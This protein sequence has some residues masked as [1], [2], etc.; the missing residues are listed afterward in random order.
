MDKLVGM[1]ATEVANLKKDP[2][3]GW[4]N[5]F[6]FNFYIFNRYLKKYILLLNKKLRLGY[7]GINK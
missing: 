7:A 2:A 6:L 1:T 4:L 5:L 3:E